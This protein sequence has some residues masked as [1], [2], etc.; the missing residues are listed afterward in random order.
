MLERDG[1]KA[2]VDVQPHFSTN[3]NGGAVAAAA[4]IGIISTT[5]W[6]C[7]RELADG[8]L[9]QL[10]PDWKTTQIPVYAFFPMGRATRAA[11]RAIV[12]YLAADFGR[13]ELPD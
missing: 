7:R 10:L 5:L 9:I 2:V 1:E 8:S 11:G 12:D 13:E 6:A 3:E 4:G